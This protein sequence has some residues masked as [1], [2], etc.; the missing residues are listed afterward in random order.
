M[1]GVHIFMHVLCML[2]KLFY[3]II[4]AKSNKGNTQINTNKAVFLKKFRL[5]GV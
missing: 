2:F 4:G 3:E 1:H 5:L